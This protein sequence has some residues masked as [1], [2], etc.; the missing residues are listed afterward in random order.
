[1]T[2]RPP[3][4]SPQSGFSLLEVLITLVVLS[5]GLLGIASMQMAGMRF[6]FNA[7]EQGTAAILAQNIIDKMRANAGCIVGGNVST[8][9]SIGGL[10]G[11]SYDAITSQP[12]SVNCVTQV[13]TFAQIAQSDVYDW[14]QALSTSLPSGT[15]AVQCITPAYCDNNAT[16]A[17]AVYVV[18]VCWDDGH[19]NVPPAGCGT[20]VNINNG[21]VLFSSSNAA[22]YQITVLPVLP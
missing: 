14:Y 22:T 3:A 17:A 21:V 19:G 18:T 11:G 9:G 6:T 16:I 1:M 10:R 4:P 13:C 7:N 5:V 20:T 12:A 8:C 2:Q 15:G